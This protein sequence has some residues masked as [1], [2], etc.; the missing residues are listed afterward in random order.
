[1]NVKHIILGGMLWLL[2]GSVM[3]EI[4]KW[5]DENGRVHFGDRVP[6]KYAKQSE[7]VETSSNVV[8]NENS[9]KN[10]QFFRELE[11]QNNLKAQK[12]INT[13]PSGESLGS[14]SSD[15]KEP[16]WTTCTNMPSK[17]IALKCQRKRLNQY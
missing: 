13:S 6:E 1:M 11:S 12:K 5:T 17:A 16:D 3:A 7:K 14:G 15:K 8:K 9:A 10:K 4:V 2:N